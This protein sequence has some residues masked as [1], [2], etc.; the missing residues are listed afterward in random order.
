[1]KNYV[2]LKKNVQKKLVSFQTMVSLAM[3]TKYHMALLYIYVNRNWYPNGG[4]T[5]LFVGGLVLQYCT[6]LN[7]LHLITVYSE[8]YCFDK[9]AYNLTKLQNYL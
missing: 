7:W 3:D 9:I 4:V 8:Q 2:D 6:R 1:M 5:E